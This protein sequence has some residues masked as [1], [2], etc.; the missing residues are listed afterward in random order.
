MISQ[1]TS[2]EREIIRLMCED[3]FCPKEIGQRLN[4]AT[5]TVSAHQANIRNKLRDIL[6]RS[7][8]NRVDVV[9]YA[10]LSGYA[11]TG[12]LRQKY[13]IPNERMAATAPL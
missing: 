6:G 9:L 12:K 8:V 2:R 13:A 5:D 11:D 3:N 1:F 10:L 7:E 4:I